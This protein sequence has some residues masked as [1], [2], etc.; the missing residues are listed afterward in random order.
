MTKEGF[1]QVLGGWLEP[2][3]GGTGELLV[4]C[5]LG[6]FYP[7][8]DSGK[9]VSREAELGKPDRVPARAGRLVRDPSIL[10][11]R[12]ETGGGWPV[13]RCGSNRTRGQEDGRHHWG[14]EGLPGGT[15]VLPCG[16]PPALTVAGSRTASHL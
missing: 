9:R 8:R 14:Q 11:Q 1:T 12:R 2:V 3:G 10:V 5:D 6:L 16:W 15:Y 13:S 7:P 4:S